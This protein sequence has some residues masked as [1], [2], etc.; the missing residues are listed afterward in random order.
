MTKEHDRMTKM[1][2]ETVNTMSHSAIKTV[3]RTKGRAAQLRM[4]NSTLKLVRE[5][6]Q[7]PSVPCTCSQWWQ[8]FGNTIKVLVTWFCVF[9]WKAVLFRTSLLLASQ[10]VKLPISMV[11]LVPITFYVIFLISCHHWLHMHMNWWADGVCFFLFY[12]LQHLH[13][14]Q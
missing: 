2:P 11:S 3:T 1:P 14:M 5:K 6:Q 4:R 7:S 9:K 13:A 10:G 12:W 8:L